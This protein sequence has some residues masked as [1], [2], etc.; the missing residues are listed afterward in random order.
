MLKVNALVAD[1]A[2]FS[3]D[4]GIAR[5]DLS[6]FVDRLGLTL[7]RSSVD[8]Y[9]AWALLSTRLSDL[10]AELPLLVEFSETVFDLSKV[11]KPSAEPSAKTPPLS[12]TYVSPR[13]EHPA[14]SKVQPVITNLRGLKQL[15][16]G[17]TSVKV[18][19]IEISLA[20][21]ATS[22]ANIAMAEKEYANSK[23][24]SRQA[25]DAVA[26]HVSR[27]DPKLPSG[28]PQSYAEWQEHGRRLEEE[29]I[30]A[31]QRPPPL[32]NFAP[33]QGQL[34][35]VCVVDDRC[36]F[37]SPSHASRIGHLWHQ[38]GDSDSLDRLPISAWGPPMAAKK[39]FHA[40]GVRADFAGAFYGRYLKMQRTSS[41]SDSED[42][43]RTYRDL[44]YMKS[45]LRWSHGSAVMDLV[46]GPRVWG[47]DH[48]ERWGW[49]DRPHA[50]TGIRFVQL[51]NPTVADT[52]GGSLSSHALDAIRFAVDEAE[53]GQKV[54][55]NLSYG[56][57]SGGHDG[58]SLWDEGLLEL[59]NTFNGCK[60]E[61]LRKTL[62]VVLPA[63][64]SQLL[65]GHACKILND[66][67]RQLTLLWKVQPDNPAESFI[68]IWLPDG[69]DAD[70]DVDPPNGA[71]AAEVDELATRKNLLVWGKDAAS[72]IQPYA[73]LVAPGSVS[74]SKRGRMA[75][76]AVASTLASDAAQ[77]AGWISR[78]TNAEDQVQAKLR[79]AAAPHGVWRI[80]ITRT[81]GH[82]AVHAWVQRGDLAPGRV[83]QSRGHRGR[84]SYLLDTLDDP[85]GWPVDPNFTLNGIATAVHPQLHVIGAMRDSDHGVTP[86]SGAGPN[87]LCELRFE[88]PDR[89]V[90]ADQ[91][92]NQPGLL[93]NGM[94]GGSRIRL[95]GTSIA[96]AAYTRL[97]YE[98]LAQCPDSDGKDI[99]SD[100]LVRW[101]PE[102]R[103]PRGSPPRADLMH[104]GEWSKLV[105]E[106]PNG[107]VSVPSGG[108]CKPFSAHPAP[109]PRAGDWPPSLR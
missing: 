3:S 43:A 10:E 13:H 20:R 1:A 56:T 94:L 68:E 2:A 7:E 92:L 37:S 41:A 23:E 88:G 42:E 82:G 60:T 40:N 48:A 58:T 19:R 12:P 50:P 64:N 100:A 67:D 17:R 30:R 21:Y 95:S 75:L 54:I 14:P 53:P 96:A 83:Q 44:G 86:Y 9:L 24:L 106:H 80:T 36:N 45:V 33:Q 89:L 108:S 109:P 87:R 34:P 103:I 91:S 57:H 31:G 49:R 4:L 74:Q 78:S 85:Q 69:F 26:D 46:A 38:G 47:R 61:S 15:L 99:C 22:N 107:T 16:E 81:A 18:R 79:T 59:L 77:A 52:S 25:L 29:A 90:T 51:P 63:G 5:A 8:P 66:Q 101:T 97:L 27:L 32:D 73:A 105:A 39:S 71:A 102:E 84:Q 35:L 6:G 76:L 11:F 98:R 62:H 28:M 72:G 93:V 70:I 55:V 104:R 65:R